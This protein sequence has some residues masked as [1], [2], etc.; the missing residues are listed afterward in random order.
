LLHPER[1]KNAWAGG[2]DRARRAPQAVQGPVPAPGP[3]PAYRPAGSS[4]RG[5]H[6][7]VPRHFSAVMQ[8]SPSRPSRHNLQPRH[9]N[10]PSPLAPKSQAVPRKSRRTATATHWT[11]CTFRRNRYNM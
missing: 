1:S 8:R 10:T 6:G 4:A 11:F 7:P 5:I 9:S 2:K 3:P